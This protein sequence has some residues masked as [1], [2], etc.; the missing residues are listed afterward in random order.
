MA[1]LIFLSLL[2]VLMFAN[3][4][5]AAETAAL[6]LASAIHVCEE[7]FFTTPVY[8]SSGRYPG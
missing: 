1:I 7:Q 6:V 8:R 2:H 5:K 3:M 4:P